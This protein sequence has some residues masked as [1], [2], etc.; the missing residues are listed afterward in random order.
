VAPV[1]GTVLG[2]I[3]VTT[4]CL[5]ARLSG[6]GATCFGIYPDRAAAE[7]AVEQLLRRHPGWWIRACRLVSDA[8][9]MVPEG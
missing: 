4:D 9:A 7:R 6:S 3:A 5:L 1:V 8:T 2:A